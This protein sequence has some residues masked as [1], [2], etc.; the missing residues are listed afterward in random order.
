MGGPLGWTGCN[1]AALEE[2]E[3][4]RVGRVVYIGLDGCEQL[5]GEERRRC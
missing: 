2:Q 1:P 3:R 4:C 5:G